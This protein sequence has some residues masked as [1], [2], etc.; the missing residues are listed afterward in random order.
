MT[1]DEAIQLV[2]SV[3]PNKNIGKVRE[4]ERYFLIS[5]IPKSSNKNGVR[6]LIPLDDG[7]KAVDKSTKK[8]F[9]YNPIRH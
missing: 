7:L 2:L 5:V 1:K 9:T 6:R 3:Y 4:T 8:V